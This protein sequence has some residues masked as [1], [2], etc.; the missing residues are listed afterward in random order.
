MVYPRKGTSLPIKKGLGVILIL[1]AVNS[2]VELPIVS[3]IVDSVPLITPIV[4]LLSAF[5]FLI[6]GRQL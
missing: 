3:S 5:Y 4:M 1:L 2:L 6:S